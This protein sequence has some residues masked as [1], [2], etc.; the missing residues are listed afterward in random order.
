M[1]SGAMAASLLL[2]GFGEAMTNRLQEVQFL[3]RA[4]R[5]RAGIQNII[6]CHINQLLASTLVVFLK[7]IFYSYVHTML[8]SFLSPSPC[9]FPYHPPAPPNPATW[10]KLFCPYL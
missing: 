5:F 8:G 4:L 10:Q 2:M 9:P 6:P 1:G 3:L 7:K